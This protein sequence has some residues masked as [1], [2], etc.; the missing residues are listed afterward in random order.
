MKEGF[1]RWAYRLLLVAVGWSV[2]ALYDRFTW[3]PPAPVKPRNPFLVVGEAPAETSV[4]TD[5]W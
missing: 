2:N 3:K 1:K 5:R 4:V